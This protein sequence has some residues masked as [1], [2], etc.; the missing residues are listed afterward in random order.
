MSNKGIYTALSGAMA[1]AQ[2]LDTIAN[3]IANVN[4]TGFKKDKQT[5]YEYLTANEKPP[6]VIQVPRIPAS[7]ESFYDMQGGDRGFVDTAGTYTDFSQGQLKQTG[8]KLDIAISGKGLFEVLTPQGIRYTRNGK[9]QLDS[10]GR[11]ATKQGYP[12]LKEGLGQPATARFIQISSGNIAVSEDGNIYENNEPLAKLS[13]IEAQNKDAIGKIGQSLFMEKPNMQAGIIASQESKTHQGFIES[14]NVNVIKEMTEMIQATR[15][16]E[17]TQ[18]AIQAFDMIN[19]KLV[20][21]IP[22]LNF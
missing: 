12:V 20:T 15:T 7:I 5:F 9:F 8:G 2:R 13:I 14:S 19:E 21:Q 22:K 6:D 3:N 18:K 16:F 4:T 10:Q 17:S 1:Q 11:L